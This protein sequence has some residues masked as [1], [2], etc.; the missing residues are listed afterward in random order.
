MNI[1]QKFGND[2]WGNLVIEKYPLLEKVYVKGNSLQ[3]VN[4]LKICDCNK[5]QAIEIEEGACR[6]VK[7]VILESILESIV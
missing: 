7:K 3:N 1:K 6:F 5:L 2:Y 4:S